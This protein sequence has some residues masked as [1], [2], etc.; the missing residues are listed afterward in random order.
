[1]NK[2]QRREDFRSGQ[3]LDTVINTYYIKH[4]YFMLILLLYI[5][6]TVVGDTIFWLPPNLLLV[7]GDIGLINEQGGKPL[8]NPHPLTSN[9]LGTNLIIYL[10][11]KR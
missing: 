9:K 7:R 2:N 8:N 11:T 3:L 4:F 1:M 10:I 5:L 6:V